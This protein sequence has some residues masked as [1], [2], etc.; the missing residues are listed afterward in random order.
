FWKATSASCSSP[1]LVLVN[2]KSGDNQGVKFLRKF[3]QLLN[4][5]QVFDLMNGGPELGL[6]LF[7][8]FVTF[9]ILVCGGDGSVGWVLSELDKLKLHKQCQLGVLPLGTGN[10]L[11]RV[12]GWGGLCDDDAQLL[13]ILEKLERA[14]TKMLD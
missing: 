11:A 4:P 5:A 13:Q 2:S 9:R 10:D 7:Q 3:K 1:L 8:K 12:L 14:T 6:R